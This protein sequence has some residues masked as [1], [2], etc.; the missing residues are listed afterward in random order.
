M[1]R[2]FGLSVVLDINFSGKEMHIVTIEFYISQ[3]TVQSV[4][5][6]IFSVCNINSTTGTTWKGVREHTTINNQT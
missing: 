1:V 5:C 4:L 2:F 6:R 3:Y